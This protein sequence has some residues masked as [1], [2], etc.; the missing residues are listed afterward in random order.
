MKKAIIIISV[1]CAIAAVLVLT[2][3]RPQTS[4]DEDLYT[5]SL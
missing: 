3:K 1:I 4:D 5:I 2:N